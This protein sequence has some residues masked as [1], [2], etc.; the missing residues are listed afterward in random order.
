MNHTIKRNLSRAVRR[1]L[2]TAILVVIAMH[3]FSQNIAPAASSISLLGNTGMQI[4]SG[5]ASPLS[6]GNNDPKWEVSTSGTP[7]SYVP[8]VIINT[9]SMPTSS[10]LLWSPNQTG[11]PYDKWITAP[12]FTC[13]GTQG[14]YACNAVSDLYFRHT[15]T[16]TAAYPV[17]LNLDWQIFASTWVQDVSVNGATA[18]NAGATSFS[19]HPW[20]MQI[21]LP[22]KWCKY[23]ITG[24]NTIIVHVRVDQ[25]L[26]AVCRFAG[27]RIESFAPGPYMSVA[28]PTFVCAPSPAQYI[29]PTPTA[30]GL[31]GS[32]SASY[33]WSATSST[34]LPANWAGTPNQGTLNAQ[35]S[36]AAT[37]SMLS[38]TMYSIFTV[39]TTTNI[40]CLAPSILS[41]TVPP[42][43]T[44]TPTSATVCTGKSTTISASGA[45]SYTWQIGSSAVGFASTLQVS[46]SV[47]GATIY[48]LKGGGTGCVYT[49][50]VLVTGFQTPNVTV[51]ISPTINCSG[52]NTTVQVSGTAQQYSLLPG[53]PNPWV[54]PGS[55]IVSRTVT[56]TFTLVGR[57]IQGCTNTANATLSIV[58]IPTVNASA[59]PSVACSGSSTTLTA[60]GATTYT[61][62]SGLGTGNTVVATPLANTIYTVSGGTGGCVSTKTVQVLT[63]PSP[64][65]ICNPP[66]ICPGITNTLIATGAT[67]YTW[68]IGSPINVTI[69]N[70]SVITISSSVA[71][72]YTIIGTG[73]N[74]CSANFSATIPV[75]APIAFSAPN[76]VLCTNAG[77]CTTISATSTV[78]ATSYTWLTSPAQV[79]S[80]INVC[81]ASL[82]IYTVNAASTVSGCPSS[83]TLAV[84]IASACCA[85]STV[86]LT[87]ITGTSMGGTMANTSYLLDHDVTLSSATYLQNS[88]IW[89]TEGVKITV[90]SGLELDLENSHLFGCGIKMWNGIDVL[91]GGRITTANTR[92]TNSMIEDAIIAI[93]LDNI[94][95]SN[96]SPNPP[97]DISRIIFNRNY[98]GINI[99]NSAP[100]MTALPLGINGCLFTCRTIT[101]NISPFTIAWPANDFLA[102][103]LAPAPLRLATSPTTGLTPPYGNLAASF[104]PAMLKYPYDTQPS[105]I[106]V[107]I[108]NV[109]GDHSGIAYNP[110]QN[111]GVDIGTTYPG[112]ISN[113]FNLFEGIGIGIDVSHSNLAATNNVFQNLLYHQLPDGTWFGG[114][115]IN[116]FV[117]QDS[118]MHT[119]LDL[120]NGNTWFWDC[121]IGVNAYNIW[122]CWITDAI[123]RST[124]T[125]GTAQLAIGATQGDIGVNYEGDQFDFTVFSSQFHNLRK[126]VAFTTPQNQVDPIFAFGIIISDS[127]FGAEV[128]SSTPYSGPSG[129]AN[130]SE[131]MSEAIEISTPNIP[132]WWYGSTSDIISNK[133]NRA[134]RGISVDGFYDDGLWIAT[135]EILIE[136]DQ[137]YSGFQYG[138]S[139][140]NSLGELAVFGNT[141]QATIPWFNTTNS[142]SAFYFN[143]TS[144]SFTFA[145]TLSGGTSPFVGCNIENDCY[146][147][148]QF[149]GANPNTDWRNNSMCTNFA[150]L[151]L[152]N[153]AVIGPQGNVSQCNNNLWMQAP[154]C[155]NN[156]NS[157]QS[158][159]ETYCE[160]SDPT[161]SPI[162]TWGT[163]G[164]GLNPFYNFNGPNSFPI[165]FYDASTGGLIAASGLLAGCLPGYF[166]NAPPNWRKA[167]TS[168][169]NTSEP[170]AYETRIAIFPNPTNGKLSIG[171]LK[172]NERV[173]ISIFDLSGKLMVHEEN[174]DNSDAE[175]DVSELAPSVYLVELS[176]SRGEVI[177]KKLIKTD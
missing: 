122:Q 75:G 156:W 117:H 142:V 87:A 135:N 116:D 30:I 55:I 134:F 45:N 27:M 70:T 29:A 155:S 11:V 18:F 16:I 19:V 136:E 128:N 101:S 69:P 50:T 51:A 102:T 177:R 71:V 38:V 159:Y 119:R 173:S 67:S 98:I 157:F 166:F 172:N 113:D 160:N 85:Q 82:T 144:G 149:D 23:F 49:K 147:G 115:G 10:C 168:A 42:P 20:H 84:S 79:G 58:P 9:M 90:P 169:I 14:G 3:T 127:Y 33:L 31:S 104:P 78:P 36:T 161:Q 133:I 86:G 74:G 4:V 77:T 39:G 73:N 129:S 139:V 62:S 108:D 137:T 22:F 171:G 162:Y 138:V 21:G 143:N 92:T 148:F 47:A 52:A 53:P 41:V 34:A 54:P 175:L 61:W 89:I 2:L 176:N 5:S 111:T 72:S 141:V 154:N 15:F 94:S 110:N 112:F 124:H 120:R 59:S 146:Y 121:N 152:T 63:L 126:G 25:S 153:S 76:V 97:I 81:P 132:S 80:A 44:I 109:C 48:T 151:A 46:P 114:I 167:Y 170:Q 32:T 6:V 56:T 150:G 60:T 164:T 65:I 91:D 24:Q 40:S 1:L 37:S 145:P 163:A 107:K 13:G 28:G 130:N 123:F 26:P 12:S 105:H 106:G 99:S 66:A 93:N 165:Q 174:I 140:K 103:P 83:A 95:L 158:F 100:T 131:Y 7:G 17:V 118:L 96:S 88:E 43:L 64:T 57:S 35:L 125:V 8:A 68:I